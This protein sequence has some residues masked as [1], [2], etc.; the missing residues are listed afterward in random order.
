[1]QLFQF[2][3]FVIFAILIGTATH[4]IWD[5][6][7]HDDFRT[8]IFRDVLI[9]PVHLFGQVYPLHRILQIGTSIAVL[10]ILTWM[11]FKFYFKYRQ[12]IKVSQFI[13]RYAYS[14]LLISILAGI[15]GYGLF[16]APF[17]FLPNAQLDLY[18]YVGQSIN[19]FF[20]FFLITFALGCL[21]FQ[22]LDHRYDLSD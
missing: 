19:Y 11:L 12:T 1:M 15:L 4:L 10:P 17:G 5:G 18:W 21:I 14:L 2:S 8:F 20:R 3:C 6:L 16:S 22:Y 9:L 13:R 7:T